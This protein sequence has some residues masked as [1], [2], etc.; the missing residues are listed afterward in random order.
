MSNAANQ[1]N[2]AK[3]QANVA[4]NAAKNSVGANTPVQAANAANNALVAAN[5][6]NNAANKVINNPNATPLQINVAK[7]AAINANKAATVAVTNATNHISNNGPKP[8]NITNRSQFY[9]IGNRLLSQLSTIQEKLGTIVRNKTQFNDKN[10]ETAVSV[11]EGLTI[12]L[13][14]VN[15]TEK[16]FQILCAERQIPEEVSTNTPIMRMD[17]VL[18]ERDKKIKANANAKAEANAKAKAE[19]EAIKKAANNKA[20]ANKVLHESVGE[21]LLNINRIITNLKRRIGAN[22]RRENGRT[23][24]QVMGNLYSTSGSSRLASRGVANNAVAAAQ[25]RLRARGGLSL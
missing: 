20:A 25:A 8:S 21:Q 24:A 7:N 11:L 14:E 2:N 12:I 4:I 17:K 13:N 1:M 19:A 3:S 22:N 9:T 16:K 23:N 15:Q 10:K 6:A 5:K 18:E